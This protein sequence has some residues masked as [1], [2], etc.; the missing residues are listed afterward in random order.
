VELPEFDLPGDGLVQQVQ[1]LAADTGGS[2][3]QP[4]GIRV[5]PRHDLK[6]LRKLRD[7][8]GNDRES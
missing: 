8:A 1:T 6:F 5:N 4:P 3:A 7:R 2:K